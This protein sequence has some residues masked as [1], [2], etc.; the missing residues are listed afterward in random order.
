MLPDCWITIY[1]RLLNRAIDNGKML[2]VT[3]LTLDDFVKIPEAL[4]MEM[5]AL[6]AHPEWKA[7]MLAG[8]NPEINRKMDAYLAAHGLD[9]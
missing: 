7:R 2:R 1:D 5:N 6:L 9:D 4:E 3:G 8:A